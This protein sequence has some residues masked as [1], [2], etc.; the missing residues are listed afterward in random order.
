MYSYVSN[1]Q[2]GDLVMHGSVSFALL[3]SYISLYQSYNGS[4]RSIKYIMGKLYLTYSTIN[5]CFVFQKKRNIETS[6]MFKFIF[7]CFLYSC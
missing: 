6:I 2:P 4:V 7:D 3:N 1:N 5:L